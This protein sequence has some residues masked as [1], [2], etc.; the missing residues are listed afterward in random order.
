[1]NDPE[2]GKRLKR[3]LHDLSLLFQSSVSGAPESL[4]SPP[5]PFGVQFVGVCVPDHEGDA[6]LANAYVASQI[7]HRRDLYAFLVSIAPGANVFPP[8]SQGL[9]PSLELL[10][11]RIS[12]VNLSHQQLW[13]FTQNG[14]NG[15]GRKP[16]FQSPQKDGVLV[17]LEFEPSRFRTLGRIALLLDR[18]ILFSEPKVE[19]LRE[20]YRLAKILWNLNRE[21]EFFLLF[22]GTGIPEPHEEFLFERF[23]L[24]ASRFL[25]TTTGWLGTLAFPGKMDREGET[26]ENFRFHPEALLAAEGLKRPLAPEKSRFWCTLQKRF[27]GNPFP[28]F[29]APP[30]EEASNFAHRLSREELR[31]FIQ[32][33]LETASSKYKS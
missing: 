31:E 9:P 21:I 13:G 32:F 8:K 12:R 28:R 19:S 7:V 26:G 15:N 11:P 4:V 14:L 1:M 22:R 23:S 27:Q 5:R 2:S 30:F 25:G 20:G 10:D 33:E 3:G 6:F 17:F 29:A 16:L 24:T 18:V